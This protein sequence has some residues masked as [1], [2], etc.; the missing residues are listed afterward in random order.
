MGLDWDLP[1]YPPPDPATAKGPLTVRLVD[2]K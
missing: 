2:K 1:P